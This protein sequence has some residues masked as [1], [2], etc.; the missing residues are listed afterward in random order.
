MKE[1]HEPESGRD[2]VAPTSTVETI[3][4]KLKFNGTNLKFLMDMLASKDGMVRLK[5]RK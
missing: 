3:M 4:G 5:A 2:A 1:R